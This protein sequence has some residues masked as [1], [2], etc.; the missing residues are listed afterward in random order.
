[1]EMLSI[2]SIWKAARKVM[3]TAI[4]GPWHFVTPSPIPRLCVVYEVFT[5]LLHMIGMC[6]TKSE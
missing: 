5:A 2:G 4:S 3:R 1:M 6:V